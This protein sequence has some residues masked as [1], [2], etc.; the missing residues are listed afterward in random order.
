MVLLSQ[1]THA[2]TLLAI[3]SLEQ[4]VRDNHGRSASELSERL[5]AELRSW[6]PGAQTQQDDVTLPVV[7]V[8]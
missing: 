6:Q 4:V 1:K 7:D 3:P 2:A 5:L 8:V